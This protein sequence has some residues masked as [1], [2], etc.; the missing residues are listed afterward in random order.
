MKT[1]FPLN[2]F[3]R[4]FAQ[5]CQSVFVEKSIFSKP[6]KVCKKYL[7]KGGE[8]GRILKLSREVKLKRVTK[9]SE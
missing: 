4:H 3:L 1:S 7:T 9:V 6:K 5:K 2:P 8:S